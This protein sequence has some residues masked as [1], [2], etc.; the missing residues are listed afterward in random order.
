[1]LSSSARRR[2]SSVQKSHRWQY[3]VLGPTLHFGPQQSAVRIW[4][5]VGRFNVALMSIAA[6]MTN[7]RV[8]AQTLDRDA[9]TTGRPVVRVCP[10]VHF[11][12]A[13]RPQ[14]HQ[15]AWERRWWA[16]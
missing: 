5:S 11:G 14:T 7:V 9:V 12:D 3:P 4:L 10:V 2:I 1:M 6:E 8:I 15:R 16:F 13:S